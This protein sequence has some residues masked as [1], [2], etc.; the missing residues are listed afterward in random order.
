MRQYTHRYNTDLLLAVLSLEFD[1]A[2]A[3]ALELGGGEVHPVLEDGKHLD[4]VLLLNVSVYVC[5]P[6]PTPSFHKSTT[7][8]QQNAPHVLAASQLLVVL[9]PCRT[10]HVPPRPG[11]CF[12][13]VDGCV[14]ACMCGER[15]IS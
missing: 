7:Q 10:E 4:A 12:V 8:L 13:A 6:S 14:C 1:M 2:L 9:L 3:Q 11:P 5:G 15:V